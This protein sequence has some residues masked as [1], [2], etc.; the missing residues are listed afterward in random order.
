MIEVKVSLSLFLRACRKAYNS[1]IFNVT[2]AIA[3]SLGEIVVK[4]HIDAKFKSTK[5]FDLIKD[6]IKI[7]VKTRQTSVAPLP[8][9]SCGV[10]SVK[11]NCDRY[12]FVK[13]LYN[14]KKAWIV[15]WI[16]KEEFF[17]KAKK[18]NISFQGINELWN[19]YIAENLKFIKEEFYKKTQSRRL[20]RAEAD[21]LW[22]K[23][24]S[25]LQ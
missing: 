3:G 10:F 13:V 22:Q 8:N 12:Y 7:E 20:S 17:E 9:Y 23:Y 4:E 15:G 11:Q 1:G 2:R 6:K 24:A 19:R 18:R 25:Y 16:T 14:F 21:R 5:D